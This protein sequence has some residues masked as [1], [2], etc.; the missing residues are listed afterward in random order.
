MD[1]GNGER[2]VVHEAAGTFVHSGR[3][4]WTSVNYVALFSGLSLI[5]VNLQK[6]SEAHRIIKT[7]LRLGLPDV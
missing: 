1:S 3:V 5:T 6:A 2:G 4:W 7:E